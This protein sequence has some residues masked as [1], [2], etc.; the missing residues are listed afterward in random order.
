MLLVNAPN[1]PTGWTLTRDEQR[2][3]LEH[4]RR[5]GTWIVADEVYERLWFGRLAPPRLR[6]WTWPD[7]RTG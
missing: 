7:P 6:S 3:L 4:C 1:N 2:A 5:T